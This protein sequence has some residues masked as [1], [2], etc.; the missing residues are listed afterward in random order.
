MQDGIHFLHL[1]KINSPLENTTIYFQV[2]LSMHCCWLYDSLLYAPWGGHSTYFELSPCRCCYKLEYSVRWI[3]DT[4][5]K[6]T[7][8]ESIAA[9][10][11]DPNAWRHFTPFPNIECILD[12]LLSVILDMRYRSSANRNN[13]YQ[14]SH[15][16]RNSK[17]IK[18]NKQWGNTVY[19]L[20]WNLIPKLWEARNS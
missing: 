12:H 8:L 20:L 13:K 6:K 4:A 15:Y 1:V 7:H 16:C 14:E 18:S 11:N 3:C 2:D 17:S 19:N 9:L 10:F 5:S